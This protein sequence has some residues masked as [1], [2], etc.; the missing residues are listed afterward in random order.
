VPKPRIRK[1]LTQVRSGSSQVRSVLTQVH[2]MLSRVH[3]MLSQVEFASCW[4]SH[5]AVTRMRN[6]MGTP[7]PFVKPGPL[8]DVSPYFAGGI[9]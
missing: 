2:W 4:F 9:A 6:N 5:S 3:L 7:R 1:E 8:P